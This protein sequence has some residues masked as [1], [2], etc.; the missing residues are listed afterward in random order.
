VSQP[1]NAYEPT[2]PLCPG[3]KAIPARAL[4]GLVHSMGQVAVVSSGPAPKGIFNPF[5]ISKIV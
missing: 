3:G 1:G 5:S 2:Q 4:A